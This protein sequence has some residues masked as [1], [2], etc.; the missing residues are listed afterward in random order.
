[1]TDF[2][3]VN[4]YQTII[5]F[6]VSA[7]FLIL[8][9]NLQIDNITI[10]CFFLI[11]TIGVSHGS[12]D[13]IKGYKLLKIFKVKNKSFF[14]LGYIFISLGII[15]LWLIL[16]LLTLIIFLIIASYHFGKE[17]A[18]FGI[19]K[20]FE[21]LNVFLFLKG[22]LVILA[23]LYFN[24]E[25]TIKIFETLNVQLNIINDDIL[26]IFILLSLISNFFINK[27]IFFS[28]L[29]SFTIIMLNLN[30]SP[31]LS[32]TIYFCFLHSLRHSFSLIEEINS[33]NIKSGFLQFLKKSAPLTIITAIIF[34]VS[35]FFLN[36]YYLLDSAIL[37]VIFIGLASLTFPHILL[38]YLLEKNE[39]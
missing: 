38:E 16:P 15:C 26:I 37:K 29:D 19:N 4:K 18:V 23:P 28:F 9:I 32:F 35:I 20:N 21:L 7:I 14:Y 25:E 22:S 13:H 2:L 12:L 10:I 1:M 27:N 6:L 17:D 11:A 30:F 33:K 8:N 36:K 31:L 39:K 3:Q 5:L 24:T 34:F